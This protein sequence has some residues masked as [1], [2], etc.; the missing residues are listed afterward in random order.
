MTENQENG[1]VA[2]EM[3]GVR[4]FVGNLPFKTRQEDLVELFKVVDRS[5]CYYV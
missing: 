3:D 1:V 4:I 5:S 2:T